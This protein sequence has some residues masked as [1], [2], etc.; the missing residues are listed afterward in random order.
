[1]NFHEILHLYNVYVKIYNFEIFF[2]IMQSLRV[3][4][5]LRE[6]I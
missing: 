6:S 3:S 1:M 5:F 4:S 2:I